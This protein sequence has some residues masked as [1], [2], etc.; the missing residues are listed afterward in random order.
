MSKRQKI[1][2]VEHLI[3]GFWYF[4]NHYERM[5]LFGVLAALRTTEPQ[6]KEDLDF[7]GEIY[8]LRTDDIA[9]YAAC[10][11]VHFALPLGFVKSKKTT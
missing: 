3:A 5:A 8:K 7:L 4:D 6:L 1:T 9:T 2:I 10:G 11:Y